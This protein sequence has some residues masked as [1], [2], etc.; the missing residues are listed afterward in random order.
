MRKFVLG[1][2]G[3]AVAVSAQSTI[4][5]VDN[6]DPFSVED[7]QCLKGQG[8]TYAIPRGYQASEGNWWPVIQNLKN[9]KAA[10][11]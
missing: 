4:Y 9:A 6:A 2:A 5:G 1:T 11:Y 7:Y 10:G 8:F 3:M